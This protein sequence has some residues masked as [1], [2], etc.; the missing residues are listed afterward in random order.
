MKELIF[1]SHNHN[2][3]EEVKAIFDK[4]NIKSLADLGYHNQ[5][6]ETA[7]TFEGNALIKAKHIFKVF[8]TPVF[9][10]DS[11]LEVDVLDG[12]P[13]VYSARYAGKEKNHKKNN[14]KLLNVLL[15]NNNR[16][17][18]FK[19]VI[20]YVDIDTEIC[21][22]GIVRGKIATKISGTGGFGYDPLFIPEG[23]SET[24]GTLPIEIK[25]KLSHRT[26]AID[27]LLNHLKSLT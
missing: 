6:S 5:I 12:A 15:D 16:K 2:K 19:T 4:H 17:A 21:F 14:A 1:A 3:V 22:E 23:Y 7:K 20:S 10:D 25:L 11:G 27:G 13:G 24:F 9:A 8:K 18:Q 26:R